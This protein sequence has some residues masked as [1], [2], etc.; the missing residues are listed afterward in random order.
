M[1]KPSTPAHLHGDAGA[2]V[3][4]QA[5]LD[6]VQQRRVAQGR[7]GDAVAGVDDG[8]HLLDEGQVAAGGRGGQ[9]CVSTECACV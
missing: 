9:L 3:S 2:G 8:V 1:A 6:D 5:A 7:E 4:V